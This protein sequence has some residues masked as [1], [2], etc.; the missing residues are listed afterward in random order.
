MVPHKSQGH[1][2]TPNTINKRTMMEDHPHT[3]NDHSV[4]EAPQEAAQEAAPEEG[5]EVAA[6]AAQDT[7]PARGWDDRGMRADYTRKTQALAAERKEMQARAEMLKQQEARLQQMMSALAGTPADELPDYD[8]FQPES[9][10]AHTKQRIYEEHIK[11]LQQQA[12]QEQARAD[13]AKVQRENPEIF[14]NEEVKAELVAFLKERPNYN[15]QDGIEI[16][17]TR[18][19]RRHAEQE[20]AR[21]S[22]S[23]QASRTAAMMATA[24]SRRA[25]GRI[26]K[27]TRQ[28]LRKMTAADIL[29]LSKELDR[30]R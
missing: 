8:P 9:V 11:P 7:P 30:G 17:K 12:Q 6:E 1:C 24:G 5:Q 25:S 4:D 3:M 20:Q 16:I 22:A 21:R 26:A 29:A 14:D 2:G 13:F 23:R 27:P 28:E 19:E 18:L 10:I 15:L